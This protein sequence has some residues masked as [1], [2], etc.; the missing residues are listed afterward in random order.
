MELALS[1][2]LMAAVFWLILRAIGQR[3]LL[4]ILEPV[5]S[6]SPNTFPRVSIIVPARNEQL[7]I[8]PCV[9][10]LLNQDY[11]A[12]HLSIVVV[13]DH[14]TDSTYAIASS[15]ARRS[16]QVRLV[17]SP[18]LPPRWVGKSHACWIGSRVAHDE[19]EWLCFI[20]AD[21]EAEPALLTSAMAV[22]ISRHF[23]LLSLAPHQRLGSFAERLVIPCGL[24]LMAFCQD[25]ARIQAQGSDKVTATGQFMLVRRR[26]YDSVGG[27][28]A[29]HDAICEDVELALMIKRSGGHVILQDGKFLLSARMYTGWSSLWAG[30]SKNLVDMLGGERATLITAAIALVLSWACVLVPALDAVSCTHGISES[31]VALVPALL[32][33]LAGFGL[34]LAG[35][36]YFQIPFWYGLLFPL[37]YTVGACLALESLRRRRGRRIVW[38]GRTYP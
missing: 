32:G 8:G 30:I 33:S 29:V 11:S 31:C 20:D 34:H 13:D 24:Y 25:L 14:S 37:G 12:E 27:H 26:A 38:K 36:S 18:T 22:A 6:R 10:A 16:P 7:N 21:V 19:D 23:D 4:P 9:N 2:G 3:H 15:I 28:A 35:A 1:F 5:A 17:Q